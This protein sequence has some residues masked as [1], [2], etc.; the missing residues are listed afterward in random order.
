VAPTPATAVAS[1]NGNAVALAALRDAPLATG[2]TA[3]DTYAMALANVG[4]SVQSARTSS[5]LSTAA[6]SQA[7]QARSSQAG[8]NLDEEL[9]AM[10][11]FQQSYAAST[12]LIQAAKDMFDILLNLR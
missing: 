8:V 11:R 1:N 10:T 6:S 3:T 9:V 12:R 7:E 2:H 5:D 4:V